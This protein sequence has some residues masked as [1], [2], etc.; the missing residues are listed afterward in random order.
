MYYMMKDKQIT[1]VKPDALPVFKTLRVAAYARVSVD[2]DAAEHSITNQIENY[3][4]YIRQNPCWSFVGVYADD[5]YTGTKADRPGF[6]NLLEDC[7][8]GRI[9]LIL[10]KS[11]SR[12]ARNTVDLLNTLRHLKEKGINVHFEKENIDSSSPSGELMLTLLASF[13]QEESRSVSENT[14]WIIRK[15]F[16]LG[17]V[18]QHYLYGYKWTGSAFEIVPQQAQVIRT[19]FSDYLSGLSPH[20]IAKKLNAQGV[21]SIHGGIFHESHVWTILR[22]E[23]YKGDSLLQKTFIRDHISKKKVR[24]LGEIAMYYA[25]GTHPQIIEPDI[26]Q[27]VQDEIA[28]RA[29]LGY[30]ASRSRTFSCFTAK[31]YCAYCGATFRRRTASDNSKRWKC[32]SKID[33]RTTCPSQYVPEKVLYEMS[34][35]V[36]GIKEFTDEEFERKVERIVVGAPNTLTFR[37]KDGTEVVKRWH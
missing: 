11:I 8:A 34:S 29:Q 35:E 23:K 22:L 36:I 32:G 14:K 18:H 1:I 4:R 19:I 5:G 6:Q 24:N 9:D 27:T 28:R 16:E 2:T 7:E 37:M 31:V 25:K 10:A 15:R 12:F 26:F 3:S 20:E 33:H 21:K 17:L 30:R 13:A